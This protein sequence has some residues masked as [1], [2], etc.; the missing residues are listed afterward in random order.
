MYGKSSFQLK[1]KDKGEV[2]FQL[3]RSITTCVKFRVAEVP[4][5][6][7]GGNVDPEMQR[8]ME[9]ETHKARFV[10]SSVEFRLIVYFKGLLSE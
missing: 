7:Q 9:M 4:G 2:Y 8:F 1:R 6:A 5:M 3:K 10:Y